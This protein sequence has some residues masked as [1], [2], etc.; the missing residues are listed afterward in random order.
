M[1]SI[2]PTKNGYR[3]QVYVLRQRAS[4]VLRT[5]REAEAWAAAKETELRTFVATPAGERTALRA[6]LERYRDEVSPSKR[7]HRWEFVRINLFLRHPGLPLDMPVGKITPV[8][9]A[10]FRD[11]RSKTL[12]PNSVI[13]EMAILSAVF[14]QARREWRLVQS[15]PVQDV[16]R[17]RSP[18][19]RDVVISRHQIK[20]MLREMGYSPQLPIRTVSQAVA[21]AFLAALRTGMRAGELCGLTWDRVHDGYCRTP[22]KVGRTAASLRDVPLTPK[23]LRIIGKMRGFDPALVFG[24]KTASLDAM[25]RKYRERAGLDGFTFHDTR[26]TAATWLARK[27]DV[28]TLCKVFGWSRM[29]QALTYYNP[30]AADIARL[31]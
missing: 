8:E 9:I 23:A 30:K 27:I 4:A 2:K 6:V 5:K 28:L 18:D 22:H 20:A 29:D 13:R 3:A 12:A 7:G 19:H 21:C 1:A 25:F 16:R 15:N 17:P 31:I 11:A 26:H 14:E 24:L 10:A